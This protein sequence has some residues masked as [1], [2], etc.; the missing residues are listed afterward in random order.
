VLPRGTRA[1]WRRGLPGLSLSPAAPPE[2]MAGRRNGAWRSR[3]GIFTPSPHRPHLATTRRSAGHC[4][5]VI[6]KKSDLATITLP[7]QFLVARDELCATGTSL[8]EPRR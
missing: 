7:A 4:H 1:A 5:Y 2:Q 8:K 3:L 6:R